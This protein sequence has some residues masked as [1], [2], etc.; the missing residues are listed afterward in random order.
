[1]P[2]WVVWLF[3][4]GAV[5]LLLCIAAA[6]YQNYASICCN[7]NILRKEISPYNFVWFWAR[8]VRQTYFPARIEFNKVGGD[9]L[10]DNPGERPELF[11]VVLGETA[12]AQNF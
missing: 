5:L 3:F 6:Y 10:I 11:V 2:S 1:M 8:A 4:S 12:R 9:A 7:H